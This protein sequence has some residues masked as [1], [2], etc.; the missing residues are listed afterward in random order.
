MLTEKQAKKLA[1]QKITFNG[2]KLKE[3]PPLITEIRDLGWAW[4]FFYNSKEFMETGDTEK[5]YIGAAPVLVDKLDE[6]QHF[7]GFA[8]MTIEESIKEYRI[9]KGYDKP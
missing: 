2:L 8:W 6:S 1:L 4:I 3:N 7:L 9:E 5:A